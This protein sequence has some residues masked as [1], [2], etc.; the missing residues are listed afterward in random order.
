MALKHLAPGSA[1]HTL[2]HHSIDWP[3]NWGEGKEGGG[4]GSIIQIHLNSIE[5]ALELECIQICKHCPCENAHGHWGSSPTASC[6]HPRRPPAPLTRRETISFIRLLLSDFC[7][8]S[9]LAVSISVELWAVHLWSVIFSHLPRICP[10]FTV[11]PSATTNS[12]VSTQQ[13]CVRRLVRTAVKLVKTISFL[14]RIKVYA[15][16]PVR[17]NCLHWS[18]YC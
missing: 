11:A 2:R 4:R 3:S 9:M 12:P 17:K 18:N 6:V 13:R 1:T 7:P 14:E 16:R 5:S 10:H 15:F 8:F